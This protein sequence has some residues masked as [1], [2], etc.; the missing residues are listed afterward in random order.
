MNDEG[1]V[2]W[3]TVM[4]ARK[5]SW[6]LMGGGRTTR[7]FLIRELDV[8][9]RKVFEELIREREVL[10]GRVGKGYEEVER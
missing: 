7:R 10:M 4:G 3:R 8:L 6:M 2:V 5:G 9:R 1:R